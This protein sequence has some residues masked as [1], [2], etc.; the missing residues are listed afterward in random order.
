MMKR[1]NIQKSTGIFLYVQKTSGMFLT[2]M[3]IQKNTGIFLYVQKTT[4]I[5]LYVQKNP[6]MNLPYKKLPVC[7]Q[8]RPKR[9]M[10][11]SL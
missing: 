10:I 2:K 4:G 5:F 11:Q 1:Q 3:N 8:G 9:Q 7:V 6:C